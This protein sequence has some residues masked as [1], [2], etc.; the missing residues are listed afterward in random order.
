M[1]SCIV[2][3]YSIHWP[4]LVT[5]SDVTRRPTAAAEEAH[6]S[7][8]AFLERATGKASEEQSQLWALTANGCDPDDIA[9]WE[10]AGTASEGSPIFIVGFPR[11]GTT[12]LEQ[13]LDAHPLLQSMDEQ[14]FLLRSVAR[15]TDRGIRY[16]TELGKLTD[17]DRK[18]SAPSIGTACAKG[19]RWPQVGGLWTR[20]P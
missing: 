17:C 16:P 10:S 5:R 7:Q 14:P 15:V 20:I 18:T 1:N 12:L 8:L 13:V 4:R 19:C 3:I 11:S 6:R 9:Q 2:T